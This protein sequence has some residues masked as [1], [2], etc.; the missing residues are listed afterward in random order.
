MRPA[1]ISSRETCFP[2]STHRAFPGATTPQDPVCFLP[3]PLCSPRSNYPSHCALPGATTLAP[4]LKDCFPH[5]PQPTCEF[6]CA[7]SHNPPVLFSS[8]T[9]CV[10]IPETCITASSPVRITKKLLRDL[11][12]QHKLYVTPYLNDT[13]YLHYKGF[14]HIEN[15]E[16]YTGLKCLWLESNGLQKIENLDAQAELRCLFLHQ[17]LINKIE[18]IEHLQKLDS[19]NLSN[20]YIRTIENLSSLPVLS[21]LQISHNQLQTVEDIVHL[22]ECP[23]IRVLDLS[24]NKLHDP[25]VIRI[26]EEMPN[27]HVLNL[28]GN[29]LVKKIPNYRKTV[30][31]QL[32]ELTYLDD[33]PVFPKDRA[34]AEAWTR[35]GREAENDEREKWVTR[36]RKKIQDSFD[37]LS[38]IKRKAEEKRNQNAMEEKGFLLIEDQAG[39]EDQHIPC[40]NTESQEKIKRFVEE[41][42]ETGEELYGETINTDDGSRAAVIQIQLEDEKM[43]NEALPCETMLEND[44]ESK[45]EQRTLQNNKENLRLQSRSSNEEATDVS[46]YEMKKEGALTTEL[47]DAEDIETIPLDFTSTKFCIADLPDL[48]DVDV[49][50]L[51]TDD[52]VR[53]NKKIYRPKIEIISGDSEGS[54]TEWEREEYETVEDNEDMNPPEKAFIHPRNEKPSNTLYQESLVAMEVNKGLQRPSRPLIVELDSEPLNGSID[55]TKE[56]SEL[57]T[58]AAASLLCAQHNDEE[59]VEYG[60]D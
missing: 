45:E 33:R 10:C 55:E 34:C 29:E 8:P 54:D 56:V 47:G 3:I 23:S 19:I 13:L 51:N 49:N 5:H 11:C 41:V 37:A 14:M 28:M 38:E 43:I 57:E 24:H 35:G 17:N 15:L 22:R 16:E 21:T 42:I 25:A 6:Q 60:L 59:D 32:K 30:T 12:K 48:E 46:Q 2:L 20:N 50:E 7:L 1:T 9:N 27:L 26:L 44:P 58:K 31:V 4:G 40:R 18:N 53:S 36:E 52:L 39:L